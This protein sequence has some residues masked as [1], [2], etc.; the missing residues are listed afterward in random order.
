MRIVDRHIQT[1]FAM[2]ILA[3]SG[4][5]NVTAF[6]DELGEITPDSVLQTFKKQV[7]TLGKWEIRWRRV[8]HRNAMPGMAAKMAERTQALEAQIAKDELAKAQREFEIRYSK[9][10]RDHFL[11]A[12]TEESLWVLRLRSM[13][14]F[15]GAKYRLRDGN[16]TLSVE[17]IVN[18]K[19]GYS[20][21][22]PELNRVDRGEN[23]NALFNTL[24]GCGP[25]TVLHHANLIQARNKTA[26]YAWKL[27]G[28]SGSD[29]SLIL[30][31]D[32]QPVLKADFT[33]PSFLCTQIITFSR[34]GKVFESYIIPP[35]SPAVETIPFLPAITEH[36]NGFGT[37]VWHFVNAKL[38]N[39]DLR[40][41]QTSSGSPSK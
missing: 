19:N 14:D 15:Y 25:L 40:T 23:S 39:Q 5:I 29:R 18:E 21:N 26:I 4:L 28:I 31:Q 7:E 37:S 1:L 12:N 33:V 10:I 11:K 20:E 36:T 6:G 8:L 17:Y 16:E 3:S 30:T 9:A 27:G 34:T 24:G 32:G 35:G 38:S 22:L 13:S 41:D 2:G